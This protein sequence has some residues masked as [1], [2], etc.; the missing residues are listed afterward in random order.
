MQFNCVVENFRES[1][2]TT[3]F[4]SLPNI[5]NVFKHIFSSKFRAITFQEHCEYDLIAVFCLVAT[6]ATQVLSF[7]Q[8]LGSMIYATDGMSL[9]MIMSKNYI[10]KHR[11]AQRLSVPGRTRLP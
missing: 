2:N 5:S 11:N 7:I 6:P 1:L 10:N 8:Y 4:S 3:S 9:E